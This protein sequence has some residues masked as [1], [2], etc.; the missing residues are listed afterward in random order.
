[1]NKALSRLQLSLNA[2]ASEP[3]SPSK[4]PFLSVSLTLCVCVCVCDQVQRCVWMMT[5]VRVGEVGRCMRLTL[6]LSLPLMSRMP[7]FAWLLAWE[8]H[9]HTHTRAGTHGLL[10]KTCCIS[11]LSWFHVAS[12]KRFDLCKIKKGTKVWGRERPHRWDPYF[13]HLEH[14]AYSVPRSKACFCFGSLISANYKAKKKKK[15]ILEQV[16]ELFFQILIRIL[17]TFPSYLLNTCVLP[18]VPVISSCFCMSSCP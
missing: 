12:E 5:P 10:I 1:M 4:A 7:L 14:P 6:A 8:T 2:A 18:H 13:D 11:I 15:K 17:K 3:N 16:R 9:K